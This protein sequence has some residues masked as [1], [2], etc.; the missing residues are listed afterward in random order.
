MK[1][2]LASASPRRSELLRQA[3]LEFEVIP[4]QVE[5]KMEGEKPS[6][7]VM[8]L[9]RQKAED[10]FQ[11]IYSQKVPER[12]CGDFIVLGADT[13]VVCDGRRLGKPVNEDDA[14]S[15]LKL[16]RGRRHEVYT[17]VFMKQ[18]RGGEVSSEAFFECTKVDMYPISDAC[19][20]WYVGTGEPMDK[21]GRAHV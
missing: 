15:M 11:K 3:G 6:D 8:F 17:G 19:A 13:I 21:I 2:I 1:I 20:R 9:A 18:Y 5:E 16:L 14:F 4:S 12:G 10:V 7:V